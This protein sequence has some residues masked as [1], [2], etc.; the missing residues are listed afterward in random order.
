MRIPKSTSIIGSLLFITAAAASVFGQAL[1]P[2][3]QAK[4]DFGL[5]REPN[6]VSRWAKEVSPENALPEYPRPQMRRDSWMNLNGMWDFDLVSGSASPTYPRKI[7][8]PFPVESALS[9][10]EEE[11]KPEHTIHYRRD[12]TVP[13]SMKGQRILLHFGAVDWEAR[14]F[15]NGQKVGTHRGGYAPFHFDVTEAM[16]TDGAQEVRVEVKD[17][18]D[19]GFQPIGKQTLNPKAIFYNAVSGIWGTVWLEGVPAIYVDRLEMVPDVVN[20]TLALTVE[21]QGNAEGVLVTAT[22]TLDGKTVATTSGQ[23]GQSIALGVPNARLWS[24]ASPTLYDLKVVLTKDGKTLDSVDSYFG[25]RELKVAKDGAGINRLFLNGDALFQYGTLDQGY[26]PDGLYTAPTDEALRFDIEL[27]KNCGFNMI[28]KHIK[29]EP[30]RWYAHCDRIGLLVWQDMPNRMV[31]LKTAGDDEGATNFFREWGEVI[32]SLRNHPSIVMWVPFNEGWGQFDTEKVVAFTKEQ[33]PHRLVNNAS[34]WHDANVGDVRDVHKYPGPGTAPLEEDRAIVLG[35]FGGAPYIVPGHNWPD[36]QWPGKPYPTIEKMREAYDGLLDRLRPMVKS[37]LAA[38]VYTQIIDVEGEANGFITYDREVLKFDPKKVRKQHEEL[39]GALK[40]SPSGAP[41]RIMC[42]GD[43]ITVGYT[44]NSVWNEP[45]KF[46]YRS[47]L[48]TLLKDAGYSFQFVGD[49]THPWEKQ[50]GDPTHGGS[51]KPEFD[52]RDLGQDNHQGGRGAHIPTLKGWLAKDAPDIVLLL[53]GINGIS[54]NSPARIRSLVETIVTEKPD[55]HLIVAQITPYAPYQVDKNQ[56]LYDYNVYIRDELV[57]S[58][59]A[60]GHNVSTVDMYSLFLSDPNDYESPVAPGKHSNNINHPYNAEYDLMADRWFAAIEALDL[61]KSGEPAATAGPHVLSPTAEQRPLTWRYTTEAP[62][63]NWMRSNFDDSGWQSGSS[64]FGTAG[65]PNTIIG[66]KWDTPDIWL[67]RT[68]AYDGQ[69]FGKAAL[70]VHSDEDAVVYLNGQEIYAQRGYT[71]AYGQTDVTVAVRKALRNGENHLAVSCHQTI[72][73]QYIDIGLALDSQDAN[74]L[75][76]VP[77]KKV[78]ETSETFL[79]SNGSLP[80]IEPLFDVALRDTSICVGGDGMYY[81]TGTTADNPGGPKDKDGWWYVNEGIRVWKS[82]DLKDWEPLGLVWSLKEDATWAKEPKLDGNGDPRHACWAPEIHYMKGTFWITYTMNYFGQ[83]F[84]CGL[85]KSTSGK[86]EGPY[87]DMKTDGPISQNLDASLFEDD[88]GSVYWVYQ[89]GLIARMNE[90]MTGLAEKP[91]N[92]NPTNHKFVGFEGAF[93]TKRDGRYYLVCADAVDGYSCMVAEADHVYGPYG[94]R[95]LAIKH[96]G[97]NTFFT[98]KDGQWWATYFGHDKPAPLV[99]R[100]AIMKIELDE[101]GRVRPMIETEEIEGRWPVEKVMDWYGKQPWLVGCNFQP[102]TAINQL[103]MWQEDTFDPETMDR[104]LGWAAELGMNTVRVYLH[105]LAWVADADGFKKRIHAFLDIAARHGIRPLLVFFDDVWNDNPK[106]GKQPDPKPGIHNSG[107][108]K[109]PGMSVVNDPTQ[110][111]R[112]ERYVKDI[113]AEF[114]NDERVLAWDLYNEPQPT[115]Q[116]L[117]A[118][119]FR[120]AREINPDQPLTV[121]VWIRTQPYAKINAFHTANSDVI[122]FHHYGPANS[123][124][125]WIEQYKKLGRPIICTEWLNRKN[126]DAV[127]KKLPMFK[128]E[129]VGCYNWGLVTGKTQTMYPWGSKPNSPE[130]KVWF[131]DLLRKD[132]KPFDAK[133]AALFKDLTDRKRSDNGLSTQPNVILVFIDDMGWGDFSCFGNRDATTPNVDSLAS[134]GIAFEQFYVNSPICSPSRVA[135]STGTYPQRWGITSF[136]CARHRN[137]L[138]GMP[139]W[140]DPKAPMLARSL[141]QAGYLTGHFGKWHMGGQRDVTEA[142]TI[143]EYGFDDFLTNFEGIGNKLLGLIESPTEKEKKYL[144]VSEILGKPYKWMPRHQITTGFVDAAIRHID[145]AQAEQKPFYLNLWPDDVHSPFYP[146]LGNWGDGKH[147]TRYMAVLEEMDTQLAKL[148]NRIKE[149]EQL[150]QN[151]IILI[152]S[153]NGPSIGLCAT[154]PFK[155]YKTQMYEGGVRSPLIV[156]APHLIAKEKHGTVNKRSVFSAIDLV[157]SLKR[158][159]GA[160]GGEEILCDGEELSETLLGRGEKS[161]QAPLFFSRPPDR[162][163]KD[164]Y[165]MKNLPDLGVRDGNWKLVCDYDGSRPELY[166]LSADRGETKNL[167]AT[168]PEVTKGLQGKLQTWWR[169]MPLVKD[170]E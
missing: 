72:G 44:D 90:D 74:A 77:P 31:H 83:K 68:F 103:E 166:D 120:W 170:G 36:R 66:T 109:S 63:S 138:R 84:G 102:S 23:P 4:Q 149:D 162:I 130:P 133:E 168:R 128:K 79:R 76:V 12:F 136:L 40:A 14:V 87:V 61:N 153:D 16:R 17:P 93:L 75:R 24:P 169:S 158:I 57:P 134:E 145:R 101:N 110:W 165:G 71:V 26:W 117:V 54:T 105:D 127:F 10:I 80:P 137:K 48:Y 42:L 67:R 160:E 85:L 11:V 155:G 62:G 81:L 2:Q 144:E 13:E 126:A 123:S 122:S 45:F 25:M 147:K 121:G 43:S 38:A 29:I 111:G 3:L 88:D 34:G 37:S 142:P 33:D 124:Q 89:H 107:W 56:L 108:F 115:S 151:T 6:M 35:E 60:K 52:L 94:P 119:T 143:P 78:A 163:F 140:L 5:Q 46:G 30:A 49:S 98:D 150:R 28:R 91:R 22:A 58:F 114:E 125:Q 69:P 96:G 9:G 95:Y 55:A 20:E 86:A 167:A 51:Y 154:K 99:Q 159:C 15:V 116:P 27:V 41:L 156:W 161:R 73:G 64:G 39:I 32:D 47:R 129:N 152:C 141:Q 21:T 104:E 7:L 19:K 164:I 53:I 132:G 113:L 97:H 18:T 1:P 139:N 157:P 135:I 106:I 65:T 100:P 82:R 50:S 146:S 112:L 148:F 8:V 59:A 118:E 70:R 92:L 131:H